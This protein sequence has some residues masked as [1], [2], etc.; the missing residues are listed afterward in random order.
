[1]RE[2]PLTNAEDL[3]KALAASTVGAE[4]EA[5]GKVFAFDCISTLHT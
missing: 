4:F 3:G 2:L 1:M 5:S